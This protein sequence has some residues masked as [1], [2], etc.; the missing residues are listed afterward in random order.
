[1]HGETGHP[2]GYDKQ[3]WSAAMYLYA[4][5]AVNTEKLP[6]FDELLQAKPASAVAAENNEFAIHAG[7]G[8]T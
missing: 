3:A 2:M 7:G 8:P 6:L 1:M 5:H 4:E